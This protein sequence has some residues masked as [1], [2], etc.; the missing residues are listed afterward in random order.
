MDI[1]ITLLIE[2]LT[3]AMLVWLTMR[4]IW[5]PILK[6]IEDRQ[7]K[8]ASGLAAGEK[9]EQ[10]LALAR[11]KIKAQ[12]KSAKID[13]ANIISQTNR[14]AA[15]I[16]EAARKEAGEENKKIVALAKEEIAAETE[17][18]KIKL[19]TQVADLVTEAIQKILSGKIDAEINKKLVDDVIKEI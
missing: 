16:L 11:K 17:K 15:Q 13:S 5:P 3:F 6:A 7:K 4:F 18:A 8:I 10:G 1:N 19:R 2:M 9:G 12:L 14:Q